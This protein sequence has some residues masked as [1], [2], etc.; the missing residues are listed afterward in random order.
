M[1]IHWS[2]AY[3]CYLFLK[4]VWVLLCLCEFLKRNIL[5]TK[6]LKFLPFVAGFVS[7]RFIIGYEHIFESLFF[8]AGFTLIIFGADAGTWWANKLCTNLLHVNIME[9]RWGWFWGQSRNY[10]GG[11]WGDPQPGKILNF[12][13]GNGKF[14][15]KS[16]PNLKIYRNSPPPPMWTKITTLFEVS[17]KIPPPKFCLGNRTGLQFRI[18]CCSG[19]GS[20]KKSVGTA[21]IFRHNFPKSV[22]C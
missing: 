19:S 15:K 14:P 18:F 11:T 5:T 4:Q 1:P 9:I 6:F 17:P 20:V 21:N 8:W 13:E 7:D 2:N 3:L 22:P 16:F 12:R 10:G